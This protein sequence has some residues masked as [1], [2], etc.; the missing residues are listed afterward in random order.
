M[1]FQDVSGR[2]RRRLRQRFAAVILAGVAVGLQT[3]A[4]AASAPLDPCDRHCLEGLLER[5]LTALDAHDVSRLP[6]ASGA[7]F[8]ENTVAIPLGDGFW[9]TIDRGS[10]SKTSR[11]VIA[12]PASGQVAFYGAAREN[13][14]GVLFSVRLRQA[15]GRIGEIEQLI[16]RRSP[17]QI[18]AFDDPPAFEAAWSEPVSPTA[19]ASRAELAAIANRYFDGIEQ[20]NGEIV[21]V[22]PQTSRVENG[23]RTAP[24]PLEGSGVVPMSIRASFNSGM[25]RY[26]KSIR[27]RRILMAD[28]ERGIVHTMVMFQHPGNIRVPFWEKQYQDPQ[29]I[30]VYP[31]S[32]GIFE[33]FKVQGGRITHITAQMVILPYGQPPGWPVP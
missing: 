31:N 20:A 21:P 9:Q 19:R 11:L 25:F 17:A 24:L 18:G 4:V 7:R 27:P 5:Y 22:T 1:A 14:H 32:I 23:V 3:A 15:G 13:G 16:A 12:D 10:Q 33:T 28:E 2:W 6:L 8:T 29:S 30:L 26:I